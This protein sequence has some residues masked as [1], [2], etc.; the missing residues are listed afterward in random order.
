MIFTPN[1]PLPKEQ[2]NQNKNKINKNKKQTKRRELDLSSEIFS[3]ISEL[4]IPS[5]SC[6]SSP[7]ARLHSIFDY[8]VSHRT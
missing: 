8:D 6:H 2:K 7:I 1:F 4:E 3:F 5:A